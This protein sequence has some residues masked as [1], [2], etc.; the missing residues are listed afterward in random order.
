M[1]IPLKP[2]MLSAL[3][4]F[5]FPAF[6]GTAAELEA[7]RTR[8]READAE[9]RPALMREMMQLRERML[10]ERF[11]EDG[12]PLTPEQ[13]A[14][15]ARVLREEWQAQQE[16]RE[17]RVRQN[18]ANLQEIREPMLRRRFDTDGDGV[19]SPAERAIAEETLRQEREAY[20]QRRRED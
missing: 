4:A 18:Q 8:I 14:E 7:L 11:G 5:S 17:A 20:Q 12:Q 13:R 15:A 10:I 9:A 19:L 2:L 6:A 16:Q 1:N 3:F